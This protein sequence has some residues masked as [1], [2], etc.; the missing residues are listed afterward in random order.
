MKQQEAAAIRSYA[1]GIRSD[2]HCTA[3]EAV[4]HMKQAVE[5]VALAL[6]IPRWVILEWIDEQAPETEETTEEEFCNVLQELLEEGLPEQLQA[7]RTARI[8][9]FEQA[10]VLTRNRGLVVRIGESEFQV[11]VVQSR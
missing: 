7:G 4:E 1:E 5:D 3:E 11:T 6:A 2:N 10:G 9:T 8:A